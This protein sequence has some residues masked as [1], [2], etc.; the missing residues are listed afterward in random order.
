MNFAELLSIEGYIF[1]NR[2]FEPEDNS[3]RLLIERGRVSDTEE[4]LEIANTILKGIRPIDVDERSPLLQID[5][6][7]Y[8]AYSV[9]NES[10]TFWDDYEKFKG[11]LFR[12]YSKSRYLDFVAV[13]TFATHD[14][15][16][17]F[18]H[19]GIVTE[20][21]VIDVIATVI[22]IVTEIKRT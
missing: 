11:K 14:F 13:S 6:D 17:P 20:N 5:F 8:I 15:P 16:G 7:T 1:L 9:K 10:F 2:I 19:Y 12:I 3:L 18:Q 22:P 4:N 21:H